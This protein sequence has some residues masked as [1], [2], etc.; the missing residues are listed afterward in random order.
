MTVHMAHAAA[1][2]E[3][4]AFALAQ[5]LSG[6][7]LLA[8][9]GPLGAGKTTFVRGLAA[10]LGLDPAVVS[11]PTFVICHEYGAADGRPALVHIDAYRLSGVEELESFG[12]DE[13]LADRSVVIVIEWASRIAG[14][15]PAARTTVQLEHDPE[16]RCIEITPDFDVQTPGR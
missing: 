12:F 1:E 16:G 9:D 13:L 10:G 14:A 3:A 4:L 5:K 15:L 11:S 8:L 7:A 6:G 2:T